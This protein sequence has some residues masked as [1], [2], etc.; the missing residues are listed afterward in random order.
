MVLAS[1]TVSSGEGEH[2]LPCGGLFI[3]VERFCIPVRKF[4]GN[5]NISGPTGTLAL[6][7]AGS[8]DEARQGGRFEL[9]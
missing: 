3:Q 5:E 8:M 2:E 1:M 9:Y 6:W 4:H 7:K